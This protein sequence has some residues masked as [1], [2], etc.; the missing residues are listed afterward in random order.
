MKILITGGLGYIGGRIAKFLR[1][2]EPGCDLFLTT[3][4]T[5][6]R[7]GWVDRNI[8][9]LE[10]DIRNEKSIRNCLS[11][12]KVDLVVHLAAI[13][14]IESAR[15]PELA[16][17]VNTRGTYRLLNMARNAGINKVIY[18]ST[19]HVYG[20]FNGSVIDEK[21]PTRPFHPYAITHRAAEDQVNYFRHYHDFQ[22]L[23]FRLSNGYGYPM[24]K[25]IDRWSLVF[26]DLCRQAVTQG[27]IVLNTSGKQYRDF[28]SLQDVARAV[29]HFIFIKK[30]GWEDGLFNLGGN[31]VMSIMEV[32][33]KISM[34]YKSRYHKT[35]IEIKVNSNNLQSSNLP[36][37][38][39]SI[40]KILKTGF[41]L[42]GSMD[43]EINKTMELCEQFKK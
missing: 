33:E 25:G 5:V 40:K 23:I 19:F 30:G 41:K 10:M 14:E 20:I 9:I 11:K 24:D 3:R 38:Q 17:E 31:C 26:N 36:K 39:F 35:K 21:I 6:P 7:P 8:K 18:F 32:A 12:A 16:L 2:N 13:N 27:K 4:K 42:E 29:H 1:E 34:I 15:Y 28:I 37:V 22:T 43:Y